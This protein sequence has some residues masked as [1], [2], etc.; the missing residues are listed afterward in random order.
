MM[1]P[2]LRR[3]R[4][5]QVLIFAAMGLFVSCGSRPKVSL[6]PQPTVPA[7]AS[8]GAV[9]SGK[10][11]G[12]A[13]FDEE[14]RH[15]DARGRIA[16][17]GPANALVLP[18]VERTAFAWFDTLGLPDLDCRPFVEVQTGHW[19]SYGGK[20]PVN[21]T[22]HAFL[23][24]DDGRAFTVLATD[25]GI[26]TYERTSAGTDPHKQVGYGPVDLAVAVR[27]LLDRSRVTFP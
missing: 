20:A 22:E 6:G 17:C 3:F 26:R 21:T 4:R 12:R 19:V 27:A 7:S 2:M 9:S 25:L 24:G 8:A 10:W 18:D 5:P 13:P 23:L 16:P 14:L 15:D 1:N 11:H